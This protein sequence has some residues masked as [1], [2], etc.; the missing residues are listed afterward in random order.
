MKNKLIN[1]IVGIVMVCFMIMSIYGAMPRSA[2][3][4]TFGTDSEGNTG[5]SF[6][7]VLGGTLMLSSA[8][9][10]PGATITITGT[11]FRP[12]LTITVRMGGYTFGPCPPV[13]T[14]LSGSFSTTVTV[15]GLAPGLQVISVSDGT[16]AATTFF[17]VLVGAI[18]PDIEI[19]A[20][21]MVSPNELG[22]GVDVT[23]PS[24]MPANS[25]RTITLE[26]TINGKYVKE[27]IPVTSYTSPG[28]SW[29]QGVTYNQTDWSVLPN[30][31]IRINLGNQ[32]VPR[33]TKNINFDVIGY[34][35]YDGGPQSENSITNVEILLPVVFLRGWVF[36]SGSTIPSFGLDN[37]YAYS[38]FID[39]LR[40]RGYYDSNNWKSPYK[41][42]PSYRT[43]WD[44]S[45]KETLYDDPLKTT[46]EQTYAKLNLLLNQ[47]VKP[48][49]YADKV[50][51]VGH[52]FGGLVGRYFASVDPRVNKVIMVGT[53]NNGLTKFYEEAF[54]YDSQ[55]KC[56]RKIRPGS[57]AYWAAPT[58]WC[59][60][61]EDGTIVPNLFEN[62]IVGVGQQ[63][64]GVKYYSIY[65]DTE[66]TNQ[67]LIIQPYGKITSPWYYVLDH[68]TASGDGLVLSTSAKA[69]GTPIHI[70]GTPYHGSLMGVH[71][72]LMR[73][74]EVQ[75]D[76][77]GL[78]TNSP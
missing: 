14:D 64:P 11:G 47:Y 35:S 66:T 25:A 60:N 52:S 42:L 20:A 24:S 28:I 7:Q 16:N 18:P 21:E 61:L 22:I 73:I 31:P 36:E 34:A 78:L 37:I 43:L 41:K 55:N 59:L 50:N 29:G 5:Q 44:Y 17:T 77:I 76:V 65:A 32:S 48:H 57:M 46:P 45:D 6:F 70:D 56:T 63:Y 71:A 58:Y 30:T 74:P 9:G 49:S 72:S 23:F 26:A 75:N 8:S 68:T 53:P 67:N 33:F 51:I 3:A 69:F 38:S 27:V 62:T 39:S 54:S 10:V 13:V 1:R 2:N 15:P 12:Y 19:K 4:A 40:L